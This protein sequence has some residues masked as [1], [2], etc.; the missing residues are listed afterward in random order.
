MIKIYQ[1]KYSRKFEKQLRKASLQ[2]KI[3]FREKR[4][5]FNTDPF[6][7]TLNNHSLTG[8]LKGYRSI[9]ITGDWR[10][11]YINNDSII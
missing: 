5:I 2:I 11:N 7:P 3:A 4:K 9:N 1:V 6:H 10:A 8:K